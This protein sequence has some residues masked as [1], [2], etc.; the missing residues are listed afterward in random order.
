[1]SCDL[2]SLAGAWPNPAMQEGVYIALA[3]QEVAGKDP[4]GFKLGMVNCYSIVS[5]SRRGRELA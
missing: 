3:V 4:K 5:V 2:A 1:M